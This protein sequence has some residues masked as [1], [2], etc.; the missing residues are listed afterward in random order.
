MMVAKKRFLSLLNE[1]KKP[2]TVL[3]DLLSDEIALSR[4]STIHTYAEKKSLELRSEELS[5]VK[6]RAEYQVT[7]QVEKLSYL[8]YHYYRVSG[9]WGDSG[10]QQITASFCRFLLDLPLQEPITFEHFETFQS[11]VTESLSELGINSYSAEQA[12]QAYETYAFTIL[13]CS[14]SA[15]QAK[16][17][18]RLLQFLG[19]NLR[20][21]GIKYGYDTL[22]ILYKGTK[23]MIKNHDVFIIKD[24]LQ[25][26]PNVVDPLAAFSGDREVYLREES[27]RLIFYQKWVPVYNLTDFEKEYLKHSPERNISEGIKSLCLSYYDAKTMEDVKSIEKKMVHDLIETVM[28]HELGHVV[29]QNDILPVRAGTCCEGTKTFGETIFMALIEVLADFAPSLHGL[30]GA[31]RNIVDV[32][33]SDTIRATR[34]FYMYLSDV[35]FY[36]TADE[37]MFLYSD[38]MGLSLLQYINED[39]SINFEKLSHDIYFDPSKSEAEKDKTRYLNQ[40]FGFTIQSVKKLESLIQ[41]FEFELNGKQV[42]YDY[43]KSVLLEAFKKEN[44]TLD[45]QSYRFHTKYWTMLFKYIIA[46]S[47]NKDRVVDY[48]NQLE[49]EIVKRIFV[50]TAGKDVAGSYRYKHRQYIFDRCQSLGIS[51]TKDTIL[52]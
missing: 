41:T 40:L 4:Y 21:V 33:K 2:S 26:T 20:L 12:K 31:Y 13:G 37:H 6:K 52:V 51:L 16:K 17:A 15:R 14:I 45:M 24:E 27:M 50:F 42:S 29:V 47:N 18:D 25:R 5:F 48:I 1:S 19:S 49:R 7:K 34:M 30:K 46:Y 28:Y 3:M 8:L 32:A 38:I 35:W 43:F 22:F 39:L 11:M 10:E 9:D 36:D 23:K 44:P